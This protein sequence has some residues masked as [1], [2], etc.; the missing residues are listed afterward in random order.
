[1]GVV[2]GILSTIGA[3]YFLAAAAIPSIRGRY[4]NYDLRSGAVA[5]LGWATFLLGF[6]CQCLIP[7]EY[8]GPKL[9]L[10]TLM[11]IGG[12]LIFT[13][14]LLDFRPWQRRPSE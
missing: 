3:L 12:L 1:M 4:R 2:V 10:F 7:D 6:A 13:G 11:G 8:N 14:C 5:N 9:A